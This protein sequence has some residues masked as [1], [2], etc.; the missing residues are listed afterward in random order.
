MSKNKQKQTSPEGPALQIDAEVTRCIRQHARAFMKTEVCG[1]LI[2][3]ERDGAIEVQASIEASNAAQAGTHVTFTQDA[4][5]EIYRVKDQKYPEHRIVGWY[6]SH[7]GFGVFL[8][9]HDT[10]IHRNFFSSPN[11]VAW[12]YDPHTDEEGCFGWFKGEIH[13]IASLSVVDLSGDGEERTPRESA[14]PA[15]E[16][17]EEAEAEAVNN[18]R[19]RPP[20]AEREKQSL[21]MLAINVVT[22]LGMAILGFA[23][24]FFL[25]P[26]R[27]VGVAVDRYTMEPMTVEGKPVLVEL[28]D[29]F[30]LTNSYVLRP[31]PTPASQPAIAAPAKPA[32]PASQ[33]A[34]Q[35]PAQPPATPPANSAPASAPPNPKAKP[36]NKPGGSQ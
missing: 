21:P 25:L 28:P 2:G 13:R 12:V 15:S 30:Q 11:Q 31:S 27:L 18:A 6:H 29:N 17:A 19:R 20:P 8:S 22:Y 26:S 10:F 7:P 23:A 4:W 14:Y 35:P 36:D 9:E 32:Q 34:T 1:V 33:P 5:E 16:E 24:C 3:E